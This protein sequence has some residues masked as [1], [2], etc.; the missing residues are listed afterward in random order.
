MN[1]EE[2]LSISEENLR[3]KKSQKKPNYSPLL[4]LYDINLQTLNDLKKK[5]CSSND[6]DDSNSFGCSDSDSHKN[7][8]LDK[9]AKIN[10]EE[11]ER[12]NNRILLEKIYLEF[13]LAEEEILKLENLN[14][15]H[16]YSDDNISH[17]ESNHAD[18]HDR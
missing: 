11:K 14:M 13:F 15:S 6:D 17:S 3:E 12:E 9:N 2:S 18:V 8:S 1:D 16:S 5:Y 10:P 4:D 7:L